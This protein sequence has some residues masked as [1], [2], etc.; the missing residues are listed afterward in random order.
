MPSIVH[1]RAC[2]KGEDLKTKT[3]GKSACAESTALNMQITLQIEAGGEHN[4]AL[5]LLDALIE[6]LLQLGVPDRLGGLDHL[7]KQLL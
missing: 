4:V 1:C 7:A 3:A 2:R 6:L 5:Q